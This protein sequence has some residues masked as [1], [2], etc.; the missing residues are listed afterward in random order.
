MSRVCKIIPLDGRNFKCA[1]HL[2]TQTHK[3]LT[4]M[5]HAANMEWKVVFFGLFAF[6]FFKDSHL[7]R[8]WVDLAAA[9]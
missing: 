3:T 7:K 9:M 5:S 1:A 2:A 8:N 6:V 4:K